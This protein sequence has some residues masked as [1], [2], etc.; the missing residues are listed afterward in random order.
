MSVLSYTDIF[1]E[2]LPTDL[3]VDHQHTPLV[4]AKQ[5]PTLLKQCRLVGEKFFNGDELENF[6]THSE[7]V[8]WAFTRREPTLGYH[9]TFTFLSVSLMKIRMIT[10]T[11]AMAAHKIKGQAIKMLISARLFP[12]GG[13][14]ALPTPAIAR[15]RP[16]AVPE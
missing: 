2:Q 16:M 10:P 13:E 4:E 9:L 7:S 5:D 6:L 14:K 3:V 12:S 15:I 1:P 11:T 8:V